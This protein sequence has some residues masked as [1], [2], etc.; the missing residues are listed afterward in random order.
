MNR[1]PLITIF[2]A[3]SLFA[4]CATGPSWS[5]GARNIVLIICKISPEQQKAAEA[6]IRTYQTRKHQPTKSRYVAVDTLRPN[7]KQSEAYLKKVAKEKQKA[8]WNK[9]KLSD[10]WV[11]PA[12]LRCVMVFDTVSKAFVGSGCYVVGVSLEPGE[13]DTFET[14]SAEY[15]GSG[16]FE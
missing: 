11:E 10:R 8:D 1:S 9:E 5:V 15:I 14:H 2:L 16:N 6:N 12:K 4:G 7:K 13:I 3:L